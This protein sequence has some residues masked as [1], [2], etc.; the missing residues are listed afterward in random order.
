MKGAEPS[1]TD[2]RNL[3]VGLASGLGVVVLGI[4][5]LVLQSGPF[6]LDQLHVDDLNDQVGYITTARRWVETGHLSSHLVYPAYVEQESFR[7]YMPGH[8]AVLALAYLLGGDDPLVWRMPGMISLLVIGLG[9]YLAATRVYGRRLAGW[10]AAVLFYALPASVGLAFS[11]MSEPTTAAVCT[12]AIVGFLHLPRR[13]RPYCVPFLV[14]LPFL[15]RETTGLIVLPMAAMIAWGGAGRRRRSAVVALVVSGASLLLCI[16]LYA[17]QVS[18]GKWT[19]PPGSWAG[20]DPGYSSIT[21]V[22]LESEV[23]PLGDR[24]GAIVTNVSRN[25]QDVGRNM[26]RVFSRL[27]APSNVL[28]VLALHLIALV[29]GFVRKPRDPFAIGA[30]A[31]STLR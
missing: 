11:A 4:L 25:A 17:W 3:A 9:V 5:L 23:P 31:A 1:R 16:G 22:A 29:G 18:E 10:I 20:D 6:H 26:T 21:A 19:P 30:A 24:L 2:A 15:F 13:Y 14:A 28:F 12:A 27:W 7:F 8:Y